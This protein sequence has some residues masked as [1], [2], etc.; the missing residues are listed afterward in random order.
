[1]LGYV[2]T[3]TDHSLLLVDLLFTVVCSN[4]FFKVCV[5]DKSNFAADLVNK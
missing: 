1:M 5:I 2:T 3:L 4:A